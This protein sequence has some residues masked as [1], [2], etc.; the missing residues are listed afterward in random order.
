MDATGP[1]N[2]PIRILMVEDSADDFELIV[3][4]LRDGGLAFDAKR[5]DLHEEL[6][7]ELDARR[8]SLVLC[9]HGTAHLDSL[10]VFNLVRARFGALPFIV[11]TGSPDAGAVT[12]VL[13][14]GAD[15]C[16]LKHRLAELVPAV[17]RAL[18]LDDLRRLLEM[19]TK[20]RDH[21]RAQLFRWRNGRPA[22]VPIC[23]G[24]KRIRDADDEWRQLEWYFYD[25]FDVHFSHCLCPGCV[26]Q[27]AG[28][29]G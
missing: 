23:A 18:R 20:E 5:V 26:R 15:E 16:V 19:A 13:E 9:D 8:P 7:R 12:A 11:V 24:C 21:L 4:E 17:R 14:R 29:A 27:Y 25:H 6:M 22:Q 3:H 1:G 28:G 2:N 10:V